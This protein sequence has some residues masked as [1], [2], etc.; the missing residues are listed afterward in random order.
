MA[1]NAREHALFKLAHAL[2]FTR[3]EFRFDPGQ[4]RVGKPMLVT[5]S[6]QYQSPGASGPGATPLKLL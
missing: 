3:G 2:I 4:F 1:W 6:L 5:A